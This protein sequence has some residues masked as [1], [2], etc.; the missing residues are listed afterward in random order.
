MVSK[1]EQL[2]E[3][4][5]KGS[6]YCDVRQMTVY[7]ELTFIE[8]RQLEDYFLVAHQLVSELK[9]DGDCDGVIDSLFGLDTVNHLYKYENSR[10]RTS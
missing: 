9:R 8:S 10:I 1:I 6:D 5:A 4:V 2:S 3:I 7:K